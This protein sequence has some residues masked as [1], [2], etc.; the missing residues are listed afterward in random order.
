FSMN[1]D[2]LKSILKL[3][4]AMIGSD[5]SARSFDGITA[6]G[7]PHPRGFGSFPRILGKYVR[8]EKVF[9]L[10]EAVYKMTGLSAK[11]FKIERRGIIAKDF[12]ADIAVFDPNTVKD[13]S[14]FDN[15]FQM[16]E[17]IYYVFVNGV[18]VVWEGGCTGALPGKI[19][20]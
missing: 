16:P 11:T 4:F 5:S 12:F 3:P 17:G 15:P 19:L 1:E 8:E 2:N 7:K 10:Q 14:T 13:S 9:S 6:Q 18:P 20:K